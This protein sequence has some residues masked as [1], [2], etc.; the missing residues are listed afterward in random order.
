MTKADKSFRGPLAD[1]FRACRR[2]FVSAAIFSALLNVLYLAPTLYMLQVYDRVVP[3]R[4][5]LTLLFLTIVFAFAVATLALLDLVRTR[6]L[7]RASARLDRLLSPQVIGAL[8]AQ[9]SAGGLR[10]SMALREFDVLRATLTGAGILAL[11]DAPWTPIYILVCFAIHWALGALALFG[12]VLLLGLAWLN[13]KATK[14]PL[15]KANEAASRLYASVDASAAAGGVLRALGMR[16][17]MVNRH[18]E[19]RR[20]SIQ[21]GSQASFAGSTYMTLTKFFRLLL[22]SLSLGLG[23]YLAI[24]QKISAGSIFAASL[25]ITRAL[26]PIEQVLGAWKN[27]VQARGAYHTLQDL[28]EKSDHDRTPTRLPAARGE[29]LLER[30]A[31]LSPKRDRM[32]LADINFRLEPGDALGVVGPS[33]AGK[34]TLVKLIAGALKP[35]QGAIRFDG[36]DAK[37]WDDEQLAEHVGYVPQEPTLFRGTVKENIARFRNHLGADP[38]AIDAEAVRAAQACG[39]HELILRLPN[40]YDTELGWGGGGLSSGQAQRIALARALYGQPSVVILDEPNAH[41]DSDGE[42]DLMEALVRL[43]LQKVT[44][45]IVAHRTGV[46]AGVDK[47]LI[48][49]DGRMEMMGPRDEVTQRLARPAPAL[50]VKTAKAG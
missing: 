17:A 32:L 3:T 21:L 35:S 7:V 9:F 19:E 50:N 40:G 29:I 49:R 30:V 5:Q 39:A 36:A 46:L 31:V 34:S 37:D 38:A 11:F 42:T 20:H 24:E 33:G 48:L 41:L 18:L 26:A 47:L 43:K 45:V 13:E 2:H 28:F 12:A 23:A 15:Q 44:V 4:G 16:R 8:L 27:V 1:A 25:L 22:Q 14:A 6:L 10:S